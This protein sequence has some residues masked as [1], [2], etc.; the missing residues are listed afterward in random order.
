ML[1]FDALSFFHFLVSVAQWFHINSNVRSENGV[2]E[3]AAVLGS[4]W[5]TGVEPALFLTWQYKPVTGIISHY[6]LLMMKLQSISG[7]LHQL[8]AVW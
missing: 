4:P 5:L 2:Q 8:S 1:L 7:L 6:T 3:D